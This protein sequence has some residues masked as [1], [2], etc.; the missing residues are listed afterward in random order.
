M[1]SHEWERLSSFSL[2]CTHS[3]GELPCPCVWCSCVQMSHGLPFISL[4]SSQEPLHD[5]FLTISSIVCHGLMNSIFAPRY[6]RGSWKKNWFGF[7][8]LSLIWERYHFL[9][10]SLC[11][12]CSRLPKLGCVEFQYYDDQGSGDPANVAIFQPEFPDSAFPSLW[13]LFLTASYREVQRFHL[14]WQTLLCST[15]NC[16][17]LNHWLTFISFLSLYLKTARSWRL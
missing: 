3:T 1:I 11:I 10:S 13:D 12:C 15:L 8:H 7:Y 5:R 2:I 6:L 17:N 16:Q 14:H 4:T 9:D